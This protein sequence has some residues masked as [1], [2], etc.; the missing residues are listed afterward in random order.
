MI[1]TVVKTDEG[2]MKVRGLRI[3]T[4]ALTVSQEERALAGSHH[5]VATPAADSRETP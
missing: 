2:W 1:L 3:C 5:S 4:A